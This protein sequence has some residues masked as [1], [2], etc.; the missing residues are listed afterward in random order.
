MSKPLTEIMALVDD[1]AGARDDMSKSVVV[2]GLILLRDQL[3]EFFASC[4]LCRVKKGRG[5]RR[6]RRNRRC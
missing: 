2:S 6:N 1:L 4:R 5:Q 3:R